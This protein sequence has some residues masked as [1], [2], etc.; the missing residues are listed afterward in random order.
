M[1]DSGLPVKGCQFPNAGHEVDLLL[2]KVWGAST[3]NPLAIFVE[4][5]WGTISAES[6]SDLWR[7]EGYGE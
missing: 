3:G 5:S 1:P 6:K 2:F 4:H 7:E